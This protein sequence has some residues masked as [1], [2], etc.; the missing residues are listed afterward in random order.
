M[1]VFL[2]LV[3]S[4]FIAYCLVV[5]LLIRVLRWQRLQFRVLQQINCD[6]SSIVNKLREVSEICSELDKSE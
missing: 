5:F 6:I 4:L 2:G 1:Y 3:F